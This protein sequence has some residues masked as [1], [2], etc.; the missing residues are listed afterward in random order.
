[1]MQAHSSPTYL[2]FPDKNKVL[3]I[4]QLPSDPHPFVGFTEHFR[5]IGYLAS[6]NRELSPLY[7]AEHVSTNSE[8]NILD[9]VGI[10]A[11]PSHNRVMF[12]EVYEK[13]RTGDG[14]FL[15]LIDSELCRPNVLGCTSVVWPL[16]ML[17][18][19][20]RFYVAPFP[21][22]FSPCSP[23]AASEVAPLNDFMIRTPRSA[24]QSHRSSK[25]RIHVYT[26]AKS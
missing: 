7:R 16:G 15:R 5:L 25:C 11:V 1:M 24:I 4:L 14:D 6:T 18:S 2:Y 21:D 22:G 13:K 9:I 10:L 12:S 19:S 8:H 26:F 20:I 23:L 3:R 17:D